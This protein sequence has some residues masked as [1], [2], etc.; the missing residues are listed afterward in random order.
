MDVEL[1]YPE[2]DILIEGLEIVRAR[3]TDTAYR[4]GYKNLGNNPER[5]RPFAERAVLARK[6]I[7]KLLGNG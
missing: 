2:R 6:L 3:D 1:D 4:W 7:E 5:A